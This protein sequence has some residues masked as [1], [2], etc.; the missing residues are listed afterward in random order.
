MKTERTSFRNWLV[1]QVSRYV[2]DGFTE[3][4]LSDKRTAS[5]ATRRKFR[6]EGCWYGDVFTRLPLEFERRLEL[7]PLRGVGRQSDLTSFV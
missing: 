1:P 5:S 7:S 4:L 6:G 2:G 3:L